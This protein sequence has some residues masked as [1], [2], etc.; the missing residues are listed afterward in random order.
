MNILSL[1]SLSADLRLTLSDRIG[2]L[3]AA[4]STGNKPAYFGVR[5][6]HLTFDN[7]DASAIKGKILTIEDIGSDSFV[8]IRVDGS[9]P[10]MA[11]FQ[12]QCNMEIGD[13]VGVQIATDH[14]HLF[15]KNECRL[16]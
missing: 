10:L 2:M 7:P 1:D 14:V 16:S 3:A 12:G 5:P 6:E 8:Q 15:D 11:R 13:S 4:S 9:V